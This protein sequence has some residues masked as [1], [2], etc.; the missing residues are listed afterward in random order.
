MK[1]DILLSMKV[2]ERLRTTRKERAARLGYVDEQASALD[3][4]SDSDDDYEEVE[5]GDVDK[6]EQQRV[7]DQVT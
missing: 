6:P 1:E 7:V 4:V 3:Y 5:D 2:L